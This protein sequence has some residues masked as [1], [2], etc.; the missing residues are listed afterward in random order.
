MSARDFAMARLGV[1]MTSADD[2][3]DAISIIISQF[4]APEKDTTKED[5]LDA[6]EGLMGDCHDLLTSL[7]L[8]HEATKSMEPQEIHLSESDLS[9]DDEDED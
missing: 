9:G 6:I 2:L 1:A 8:A 7:Q 5:H 4:S 3:H